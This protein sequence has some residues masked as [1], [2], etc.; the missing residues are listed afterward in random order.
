METDPTNED[1]FVARGPVVV[2]V[3]DDDAD[4]R[5]LTCELLGSFDIEAHPCGSADAALAALESVQADVLITDLQLGAG[6]DG[7]E[8]ARAARAVRPELRVIAVTGAP[9]Q[10]DAELDQ[11]LRKPVELEELV[12]AIRTLAGR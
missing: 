10:P 8:L 4:S 2:V 7:I 11:W 1:G 9:A 12:L 3:V 5:E 6:R